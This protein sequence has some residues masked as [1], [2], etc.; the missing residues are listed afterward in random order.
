MVK[1]AAKELV[2]HWLESDERPLAVKSF[3]LC[4]I[5]NILN[6]CEGNVIGEEVNVAM[7]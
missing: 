4:G 1:A 6:G 2:I 7:F 3:K 5:S